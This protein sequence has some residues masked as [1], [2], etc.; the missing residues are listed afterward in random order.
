MISSAQ[1]IVRVSKGL[2]VAHSHGVSGSTVSAPRVLMVVS[3]AQLVIGLDSTVMNITLPA[4]Q[5]DLGFSDELR[6]WVITAYA[7]AFGSLLLIGARI[8]DRIGTRKALLLGATGFALASLTSGLAP[9]FEVLV[10]ARTVQGASAALVAPAVLAALTAVFPAGRERAR[11]FGIY[12]AVSVTGTALGLFLGGPLTQYLTWRSTLLVLV[13]F[14]VP[15][16]AGTAWAIPP[17]DRNPSRELTVAGAASVTLGLFGVVLSLSLF[18]ASQT[19]WAGVVLTTGVVLLA[20]FFLSSSRRGGADPLLSPRILASADRAGA[21][22]A[23]GLSAAGLFA[24]FLFTVYFFQD[25]LSYSPVMT[26]LAILPFPVVTVASSLLLAPRLT[27]RLRPSSA[28]VLSLLL[29][30]AG[31]ALLTGTDSGASYVVGVLPSIVAV[32]IGTGVI[33]AVATDLATDGLNDLDRNVGAALVHVVQQVG[34]ATGIAALNAVA[35]LSTGSGDE[36]AGAGSYALV[37]AATAGIYLLAALLSGIFFRA[38]FHLPRLAQGT[39]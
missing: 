8:G 13:A 10:G 39:R 19:V 14:A 5:A 27:R 21:L 36:R 16:V 2:D 31:M 25:V 1:E 32:A 12:G 33:F 29:P 23:L 24:V 11:A 22:I 20:G 30:G 28:V 7:L 37:F 26:G 17:G 34:G 18:Q 4:V 9:T 3:A 6:H 15:V 38:P 35:S